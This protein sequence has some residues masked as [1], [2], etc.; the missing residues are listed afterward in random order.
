MKFQFGD[1]LECIVPGPVYLVTTNSFIKR[2]GCLVMGRG[3]AKQLALQKPILPK[4]LGRLIANDCGH[5]GEY[6]VGIYTGGSQVSCGAFQVK[7][8]WGDA[9]DIELIKRSTD[10]LIELANSKPDVEFHLNYP[11]IGNGRLDIDLVEP[12]IDRLPD[13]VNVWRFE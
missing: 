13:N 4:I 3:A 12:I 11:G 5:L 2:D 9:A 6:N 7:Y 8:H 1:M 10:C